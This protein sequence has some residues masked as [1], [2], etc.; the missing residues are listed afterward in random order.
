MRKYT[1]VS[2][3][4]FLVLCMPSVMA[5]PDLS[6]M[7]IANGTVAAKNHTDVMAPFSGTLCTFDLEAGDTVK[8]GD[9]LFEMQHTIIYAPETGKV[10]AVFI[11]PGEYTDAAMIRYGAVIAMEGSHT[12]RI[13]ASTAGAYNKNRNKELHV[14]ETLYFRTT[15]GSREDGEGRVIRVSGGEFIV[16]ILKG[17]FDYATMLNLYRSDSYTQEN[18]VGQGTVVRRD[19]VMLTAVPGLV[20][21]VYVSPGDE[22]KQGDILYTLLSA[23]ADQDAG[24]QIISS[25]N[26]VAGTVSVA[27]GQQVWKGEFLARIYSTD[28]MEV[29]AQI[30]EIDISKIQLGS[31]LPI[32]LD[33]D[34]SHIIY[35]TVTEIS[36]LGVTRQNA[37]YYTVHLDLNNA[38]VR[39]G[40]SADVYLPKE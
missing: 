19:P 25:V 30:D 22:V 20:E 24:A 8:A 34:P 37:A 10:T 23:D 6:G 5:E 27:P 12:Q 1:A 4:L 7:T 33:M 29:L 17:T 2:L 3:V 14:G 11:A 36:G 32:I 28:Q 40:A 9:K 18:K 39:I 26:G 15:T 21:S 35:G 31:S 13:L 38:N 16:E